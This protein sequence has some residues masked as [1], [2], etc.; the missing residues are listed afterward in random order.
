MHRISSTLTVHA[1]SLP[2]AS[3][4]PL[5]VQVL[6]QK[7]APL[8]KKVHDRQLNDKRPLHIIHDRIVSKSRSHGHRSLLRKIGLLQSRISQK[9][10]SQKC[11]RA[12]LLRARRVAKI[13]AC[14]GRSRVQARAEAASREGRFGASNS[15]YMHQAVHPIGAQAAS[16]P[17]SRSLHGQSSTRGGRTR[18]V[19]P[20]PYHAPR[21]RARGQ[22]R[23][24]ALPP[25]LSSAEALWS[26]SGTSA[27]GPH[28]S[29]PRQKASRRRVLARTAGRGS[30]CGPPAGTRGSYEDEE[31][32]EDDEKGL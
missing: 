21:G 1:S 13:C 31:S 24:A 11:Y 25:E 20:N 29:H 7:R 14:R 5:H 19:G 16:S 27:A 2:L 30:P 22:A 8:L 12:S 23:T 17:A 15:M 28:N 18:R 3:T 4:A 9:C 32:Y 26:G 10:H 6:V